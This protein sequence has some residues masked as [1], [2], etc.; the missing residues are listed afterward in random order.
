MKKNDYLM[1]TEL[2][3]YHRHHHRRRRRRHQVDTRPIAEIIVSREM[4]SNMNV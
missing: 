2:A 4:H 3:I 1:V